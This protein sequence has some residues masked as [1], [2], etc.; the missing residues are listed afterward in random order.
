[1]NP[2]WKQWKPVLV[3]PQGL[4]GTKPATGGNKASKLKAIKAAFRS[5]RRVWL[6]TDSD[7]EGRLIGQEQ[8]RRR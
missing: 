6:A 7:C 3:R 8:L 2:D 4:Y 1:M 5:A